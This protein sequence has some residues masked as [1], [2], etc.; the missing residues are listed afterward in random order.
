MP[1][2]KLFKARSSSA[3]HFSANYGKAILENDV[4]VKWIFHGVELNNDIS[5]APVYDLCLLAALILFLLSKNRILGPKQGNSLA[6]WA[7]VLAVTYPLKN[8]V[9]IPLLSTIMYTRTSYPYLVVFPHCIVACCSYR[10]ELEQRAKSNGQVRPL[11]HPISSFTWSFLCYGF[12]GSIVSDWLLGLPITALGH[13]RILFCH[14][15]SYMLVWY[16][17][18]DWCFQEYMDPSSFWRFGLSIGECIDSITTPPGRISRGARELKNQVTAPL[19]GGMLAGVGGSW[20]R[21]GE[22]SMVQG[23]K[24]EDPVNGPSISAME[25]G[26]WNTGFHAV[27]WW[28]F[29]VYS[30]NMGYFDGEAHGSHGHHC[31]SFAGSDDFRFGL[32]MS[33]IIWTTLKLT[34]LVSSSMKHPFVWLGQD[35]IAPTFSSLVKILSL[36]PQYKNDSAGELKKK[37]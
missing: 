23:L 17:P 2:G 32:V 37:E 31:L 4:D 9:W 11:V 1:L 28:Y 26:F 8:V 27:L 29:A 33:A 10:S 25:A 6:V 20:I 16:C 22:R 5:G 30:C 3:S 15:I 14:I 21:Y 7:T 36:G 12:G 24:G 18:M 19:V 13:P 34:G 35:V